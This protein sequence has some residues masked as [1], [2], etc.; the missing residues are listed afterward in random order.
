MGAAR[1]GTVIVIDGLGIGEAPDSAAYGDA[2]SHTLDLL[3]GGSACADPVG[4]LAEQI[5]AAIAEPLGA[6]PQL[7][8]ALAPSHLGKGTTSGHWALFGALSNQPLAPITGEFPDTLRRLV[9]SVL[10]EE[11]LWNRFHPDGAS[12]VRE[13]G[14]ASTRQNR[15]IAYTSADAVLQIA[16]NQDVYGLDRLRAM[17]SEL[18]T[19]LQECSTLGRVITRPFRQVGGTYIRTAAR[20]D[21]HAAPGAV[22][23]FDDLSRHGVRVAFLGK[24]AEIFHWRRPAR[25]LPSN[26]PDDILAATATHG[27][28]APTLNV[29]NLPQIDDSLHRGDIASARRWLDIIVRTVAEFAHRRV[30]LVVTAD[31]GCD[32]RV[33]ATANTREL[34]P[35]LVYNLA[36]ALHPFES[37]PSM[38]ALADVIRE[39]FGLHGPGKP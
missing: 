33:N 35:L 19:Q 21:Y 12:L 34:V 11:P 29:V 4:T 31:H 32:V 30:P 10:G 20:R 22:P 16:A 3:V 8:T 26:E 1:Q 6:R 25:F 9:M 28:A 13:L 39:C 15:A 27:G 36:P 38:D 17:G 14:A 24:A 7:A 2:G 18:A 37:L 23:L 5:R